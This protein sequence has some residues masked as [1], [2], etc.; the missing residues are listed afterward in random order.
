MT[1]A[2]SS[3]E[4]TYTIPCQQVLGLQSNISNL[5]WSFGQNVPLATHEEFQQCAL[6]LSLFVQPDGAFAD[7]LEQSKTWGKYHHLT[8]S[9]EGRVVFYNR[10][11]LLGSK[12]HLEA[13]NLDSEV[14]LI[15]LNRTYHKFVHYRFMNLHSTNY[16]LTDLTA[17]LLLRKKLA[18][19]HCSAFQKHGKTV[20]I[21]A[22]SNTGKTLTTM[23]ACL[24]QGA[25]FISEDLA[26]TNG[27]QIFGLPWTSTFAYYDAIDDRRLAALKRR[28]MK[29]LPFLDLF[30][31][32]KPK[33]ITDYLPQ[34]RICH[35]ATATHLVILERGETEVQG[36]SHDVAFQKLLNLNRSEFNYQ[37][38]L[39]NNAYEYFNSDLDIAGAYETEGTILQQLIQNVQERFIIRSN[40]PTK[41]ASLVLQAVDAQAQTQSRKQGS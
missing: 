12:L 41:Y 26:I 25:N 34:E 8:G 36:T 29:A 30:S 21:F 10:P 16:I 2:N 40:D 6:Q 1:D 17:L 11:F 19:I 9:P 15:R 31:I 37:R 4:I 35:N 14:P 39:I 3:S 22:P 38:S 7:L 18:P 27:Q 28:T 33:L 32:A 13:S 20:V 5:R 24:E 23:L